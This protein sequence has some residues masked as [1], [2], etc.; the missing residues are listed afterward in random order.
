MC[1]RYNEPL[2]ESKATRAE[3]HFILSASGLPMKNLTWLGFF[4]AVHTH[5]SSN[6]QDSE[7]KNQS[8]PVEKLETCPIQDL[9]IPPSEQ[10]T[11]GYSPKLIT[12]IWA[13]L[14]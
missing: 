7:N 4:Q 13:F 12:S 3:D 1:L 8:E 9:T 5:S 14:F 2:T 10:T 6:Q 11:H